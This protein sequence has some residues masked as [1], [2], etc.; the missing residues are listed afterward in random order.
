M[1][2]F[3]VLDGVF[4][5]FSAPFGHL[6]RLLPWSDLGGFHGRLPW[7]AEHAESFF[8]VLHGTDD[9][10][11]KVDLALAPIAAVAAPMSH[12]AM[13]GILHPRAFSIM[14]LPVC[15][16]LTLA[17]G[18]TRRII[19]IERNRAAAIPRGT[20]G[21]EGR[22]LTGGFRKVDGHSAVRSFRQSRG[23]GESDPSRDDDHGGTQRPTR[24]P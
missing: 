24:A 6:G 17:F 22:S 2:V 18:L 20:W 13:E 21:F 15:L 1:G 11:L 23:Y 14:G 16:L 12:D 7:T 4:L 5:R 8:D 3:A 9:V 10:Q 19:T